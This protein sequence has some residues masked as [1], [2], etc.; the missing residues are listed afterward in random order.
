M[1]FAFVVYSDWCIF[2][3]TYFFC[4][5]KSSDGVLGGLTIALESISVKHKW[6]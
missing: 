4:E 2:G 6:D 5:D 3:E 1:Q